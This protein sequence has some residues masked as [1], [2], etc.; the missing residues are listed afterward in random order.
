MNKE[1]HNI[2]EGYFIGHLVVRLSYMYIVL[3]QNNESVVY[4]EAISLLSLSLALI[5]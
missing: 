4:Y 1:D 5:T 3:V 2:F